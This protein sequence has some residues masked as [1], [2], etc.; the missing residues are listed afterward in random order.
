M[1]AHRVVLSVDRFAVPPVI[2]AV[3]N[4]TGRSLNARFRDFTIP[5][6]ASAVI[7]GR[8]PSGI[9]AQDNAT[10]S[11]QVVTG[12]ISHLLTEAGSVAA[13]VEITDEYRVTS[14]AFM[15]SVQEGI[16]IEALEGM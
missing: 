12:D 4:D 3:Q 11:G 2:S 15:I 8:L 10:I 16:P 1:V 13:Q 5:N 9:T 14:F 6:G 7:S